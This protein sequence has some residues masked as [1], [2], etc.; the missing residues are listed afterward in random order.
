MCFTLTPTLLKHKTLKTSYKTKL[1]SN[2]VGVAQYTQT[3]Q[4]EWD[5]NAYKRDRSGLYNAVDAMKRMHGSTFTYTA[6]S[7]MLDYY[8]ESR[9]EGRRWREKVPFVLVLV[10]DGRA[11][12][13]FILK[14]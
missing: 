2:Q 4:L 10:T 7:D 1:K 14:L 13:G 12:V 6:V 8:L 9:D 5:M 11:K 3:N